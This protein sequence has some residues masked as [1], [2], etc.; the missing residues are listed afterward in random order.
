MPVPVVDDV[1]PGVVTV[2]STAPITLAGVVTVSDVSVPDTTVA[3]ARPNLTLVT[4]SRF[5][6]PRTTVC[7]PATGPD[8]GVIERRAGRFDD[9][10]LDR[11]GLVPSERQM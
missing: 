2:T 9:Q 1:P 5:A 3:V 8:A 6:P 7:P 10:R 4:P 11:F